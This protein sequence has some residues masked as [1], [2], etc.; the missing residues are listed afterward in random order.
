MST[1][2]L[3]AMGHRWVGELS[4]FRFDVKYRPGKIN[5]DADTLSTIPLDID[6]YTKACT[7]EQTRDV[8]CATWEGNKAALRKDVAWITA[9]HICSLDTRQ[10]PSALS[11]TISHNEL[12][13]A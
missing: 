11:P 4:R 10:Q 7:E 9:L 5:I 12:V 8:V 6:G 13:R 3:N 1:T 2:K